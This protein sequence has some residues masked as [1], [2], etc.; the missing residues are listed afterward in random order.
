MNESKGGS[1]K[2]RN[3]S[4]ILMLLLL[5]CCPVCYSKAT[6]GDCH[7][8]Q[9]WGACYKKQPVLKIGSYQYVYMVVLHS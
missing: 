9:L 7:L 5:A 2:F 8:E 6:A 3:E 1:H 4:S